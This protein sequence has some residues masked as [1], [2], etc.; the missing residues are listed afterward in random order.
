VASCAGCDATLFHSYIRRGAEMNEFKYYQTNPNVVNTWIT[1]LKEP[2]PA[3][4]YR[5]EQYKDG[6]ITWYPQEKS[7]DM[8]P[9]KPG[10]EQ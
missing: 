4:M 5:V 1:V 6:T 8:T 7:I 2:I 3:G 9:T 10:A